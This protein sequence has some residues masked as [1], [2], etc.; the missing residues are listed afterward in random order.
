LNV[1]P[2]FAG[3]IIVCSPTGPI[4][5]TWVGVVNGVQRRPADL[6]A[7]QCVPL[8]CWFVRSCRSGARLDQ[9]DAEVVAQ[10]RLTA[11]NS[12]EPQVMG[13]K[14][15]GDFRVCTTDLF[16]MSVGRMSRLGIPI[17]GSWR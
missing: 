5:D 15:R 12:V 3:L 16:S 2:R 9:V 17:F 11:L 10:R 4:P 1:R 6:N 14:W 13:M 8:A 7:C